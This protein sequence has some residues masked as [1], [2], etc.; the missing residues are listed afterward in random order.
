MKFKDW[1]EWI[2]DAIASYS[3]LPRPSSGKEQPIRE[4]GWLVKHTASGDRIRCSA[5]LEYCTLT[6][7]PKK[8]KSLCSSEEIINLDHF[9]SIERVNEKDTF[10]IIP[11]NGISFKS[12]IITFSTAPISF[13]K[14]TKA[15]GSAI[16]NHGYQVTV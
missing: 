4:D 5:R 16:K 6:L 14:W 12:K 13:N 3:Q 1:I 10:Q 11:R 7:R 9:K 15:I 2:T 8:I